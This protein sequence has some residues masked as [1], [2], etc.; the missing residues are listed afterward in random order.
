M[1]R[2][3]DAGWFW[4]SLICIVFALMMFGVYKARAHSW[5]EPS[6]CSGKDCRPVDDGHVVEKAD[7]V[8]VK[9][10][11]VL[12]RADSRLRWSRDDR[13]H[14]CENPAKLLC[15]YRKPNGM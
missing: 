11:G 14:V 2:L 15:V 3:L 7:G 6:C 10:W 12:N 5:Y 1:R 8:H 4:L 9:G 13:D